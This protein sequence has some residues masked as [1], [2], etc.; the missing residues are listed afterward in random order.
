ML[1]LT[2]RSRDGC[3]G[4]NPI[5]ESAANAAA[6]RGST[7][8]SRTT[9]SLVGSMLN[10][11]G[12]NDGRG[13]VRLWRHPQ[14]AIDVD[15]NV[16]TRLAGVVA[17]GGTPNA[18]WLH[19]CGSLLALRRAVVL[20]GE[21]RGERLKRLVASR[22]QSPLKDDMVPHLSPVFDVVVSDVACDGPDA[23]NRKAFL[24]VIIVVVNL[25]R[26][27]QA[28]IIS[29]SIYFGGEV[30]NHCVKVLHLRSE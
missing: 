15:E 17:D 24:N 3:T 28:K 10:P 4:T 27:A 30:V 20:R 21:D 16:E 19:A 6:P 12:R 11:G 1:D 13:G 29:R 23:V 14:T 5:V 9:P 7:L 18:A 2:R 8:S 25:P 22:L 26:L